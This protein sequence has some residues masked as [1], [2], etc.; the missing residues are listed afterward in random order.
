MA[1]GLPV[2]IPAKTG[3]V[4][5]SDPHPVSIYRC[6]LSGDTTAVQHDR[7]IGAGDSAATVAVFNIPDNS[8]VLDVGWRVRT[9]FDANCGLKIG[10]SDDVDGWGDTADL[11]ATTADTQIYWG[12]GALF[13]AITAYSLAGDTTVAEVAV[14]A[15]PKNG[16]KSI[17]SSSDHGLNKDAFPINVTVDGTMTA[18]TAGLVDI[19]VKIAHG[20]DR[21][22]IDRR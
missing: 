10:D 16:G 21:D 11:G 13:A 18:V 5:D 9:A 7:R 14:P 3:G 19:Y 6:V 22:M 12:S 1:D 8:I 15:Y 4:M 2:I 20:Y 17:G